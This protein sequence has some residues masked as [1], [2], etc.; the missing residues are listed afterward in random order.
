RGSHRANA[1]LSCTMSNN[2]KFKQ[3]SSGSAIA[4]C[5]LALCS[6]ATASADAPQN[7]HDD[8]SK[9][10]IGEYRV[11]GNTVLPSIEIEETLYPRLGPD[12]TIDDVE[13]ARAALESYYH[14]RGYGTVFVDVPEQD[15]SD[16]VGRLHVTQGQLVQTRVAGAR[17]FSGREIRNAVPEAQNNVV[18][19]IPT[20]QAQLTQLNTET[21]DRVVTPVLKAGPR[22]GT[23]QLT[24][25]V[26]DELPLRA[27]IDLNDR[28]TIDTTKL[29]SNASVSYDNLFGRLDSLAV[30]YQTAPEEPDEAK[31]W[32]A[33]YTARLT[34]A[35][36]KLAFFMID[37]DSDVATV[38]DG[39]SSVNVLGKGQIYGVR[40]ITPL[41]NTAA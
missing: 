33:S 34:D 1:K 20:L 4:V 14:D 28:Y 6:A 35:G 32:A 21:P 22:P 19:H 15:V 17:Y 18:P 25:N 12:K 27:S 31:V 26:Q 36:T 24:L 9:F 7:A 39:G 40:V 29:R 16:G 23:V 8:A 30:Q 2:S 10:L 41:E 38:G 5:W 37:S 3:D 13:K 11:L